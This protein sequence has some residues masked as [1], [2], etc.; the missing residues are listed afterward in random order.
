MNKKS[1]WTT[2]EKKEMPVAP[3]RAVSPKP[4]PKSKAQAARDRKTANQRKLEAARF[5]AIELAK[6]LPRL[7]PGQ[8]TK[9]VPEYG[10]AVIALGREGKSRTQIAAALSVSRQVLYLWEKSHPEFFD[11]MVLAR[12]ASQAWWEEQGQ[13]GVWTLGFNHQAYRMQ[14]INRFRGEW[15][16]ELSAQNTAAA[17]VKV[18]LL[19]F[20][21]ED[22]P[23][24]PGVLAPK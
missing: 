19:Q 20:R 16:D 10:E 5:K 21:P 4:M 23:R 12:E 7:R 13:K 9:Y 6:D 11:A 14:M 8:P 15:R 3:S 1:A 17:G 22:F 18:Q 2:E 24:P